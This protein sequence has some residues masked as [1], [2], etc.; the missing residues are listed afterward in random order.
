MVLGLGSRIKGVR[1]R[2]LGIRIQTARRDTGSEAPS[3]TNP[4]RFQVC[5]V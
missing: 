3:E 5:E 2:A 4:V 1:F